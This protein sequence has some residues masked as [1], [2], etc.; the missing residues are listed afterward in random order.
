MTGRNGPA[1][2]RSFSHPT[3]YHPAP[4]TQDLPFLNID[5]SA[6]NS[7]AYPFPRTLSRQ[8]SATSL[9]PSS[10][11]TTGLPGR[12]PTRQMAGMTLDRSR[13]DSMAS[14]I[15]PT[16]H[17]ARTTSSIHMSKKA[18]FASLV[19]H[20][21]SPTTG[22]I[23]TPETWPTFKKDLKASLKAAGMYKMLNGE[24]P[25]PIRRRD[26]RDDA[27]YDEAMEDYLAKRSEARLF[28]NAS[29][30]PESFESIQD[31]PVEDMWKSL[32]RLYEG[33]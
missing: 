5:P 33:P 28:L 13:R 27:A 25:A 15:R 31:R 19:D 20:L 26:Q 2:K 3:Q 18:S 29:L 11:P 21:P 1:M 23:L 4:L 9:F 14:T 12:P 8:S 7:N 10:R 30:G 22:L 24:V 6:P 32:V 16:Y 17:R